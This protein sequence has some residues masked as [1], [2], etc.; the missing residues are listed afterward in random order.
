MNNHR[1]NQVLNEWQKMPFDQKP[2]LLKTFTAGL[3]HETHLLRV[4][5]QKVVFKLFSHSQHDAIE[6]Q[7]WANRIGVA[8]RVIHANFEENFAV[9][10]YIDTATLSTETV[11]N[12]E[13]ECIAA[14]LSKLHTSTEPLSSVGDFE[15]IDF[16]ELYLNNTIKNNSFIQNI[17]KQNLPILEMFRNDNTAWTNCHNDLVAE[18]C[19]VV[20][21]RAQFID[22]E[23]AKQHN[24][25]FDLAAI[26][27]YLKLDAESAKLFLSNYRNGW[28]KH[29]DSDIYYSSQCALLWGDML[30]HLDHYGEGCWMSLLSKWANLQDLAH[31]LDI[32]LSD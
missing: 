18:N 14:G 16:C 26:I 32:I 2:R 10:Q 12:S 6:A 25:W 21:R 9:F 20:N 15:I 28:G 11:S 3:N 19:F 5:D 23:Y 29:F 17:H 31:K 22:W 8:P 24:P 30:W 7:I 27:Y 1:L 13:L 4:G